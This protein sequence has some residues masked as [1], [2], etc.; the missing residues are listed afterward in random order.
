MELKKLAI[1]VAVLVPAMLVQILLAVWLLPEEDA[2]I[3]F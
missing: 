3:L 1:S 2:V